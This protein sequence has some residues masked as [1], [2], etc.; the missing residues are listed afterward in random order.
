MIIIS[1]GISLL[2]N[3]LNPS[4]EINKI[5]KGQ[6]SYKNKIQI[7]INNFA[8]KDE[9]TNQK[10]IK[11]LFKNGLD[12]DAEKSFAFFED[13]IDF[14]SNN[15]NGKI[16]ENI[17]KRTG[18]RP[19]LLPAEISSLFLYYYDA[20]GKKRDNT[21][22][23]V[24]NDNR[25]KDRIILL[26][27][28]TADSVLCALI[29]KEIIEKSDYFKD[30]CEVLEITEK[31]DEYNYDNGIV[32]IKNLDMVNKAD[33]W[34]CWDKDRLTNNCG[35]M[36]LYSYLKEK[37]S[38]I[39]LIMRTGSYKELSADLLLLSAQFKISTYYLFENSLTSVRTEPEDIS[40]GL[41]EKIFLKPSKP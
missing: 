35:I 32:V 9:E 27:T 22:L 6:I 2:N 10:T 11:A 26:C 14:F 25:T 38:Q 13:Y 7:L 31:D 23:E 20:D 8:K 17:K 12:G 1:V 18:N 16:L 40:P 3:L 21:E 37:E 39:S 19:D 4:C 24:K 33:K 29:I 30:K 34:I 36:K 5:F 15:D 41:I 28:E